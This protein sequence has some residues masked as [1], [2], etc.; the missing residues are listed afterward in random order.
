VPALAGPHVAGFPNSR[1]QCDPTR[2]AD[3]FATIREHMEEL[4]RET[5]AARPAQPHQP[6]RADTPL[7]NYEKRLKD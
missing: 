5:T 1:R 4:R 3:D 7:T 6:P 2:A